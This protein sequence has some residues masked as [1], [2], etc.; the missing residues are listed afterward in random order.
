MLL[1]SD[2]RAADYGGAH[3]SKARDR[4]QIQRMIFKTAVRSSSMDI[5]NNLITQFERSCEKQTEKG[6]TLFLRGLAKLGEDGF[7][8]V[9]KLA[10]KSP[11]TQSGVQDHHARSQHRNHLS[12]FNCLRLKDEDGEESSEARPLGSTAFRLP[13][14]ATT[15]EQDP[16]GEHFP[17]VLDQMTQAAVNILENAIESKK[18]TVI[19]LIAHTWV[20]ALDTLISY[21]KFGQSMLE[22]V[23]QKRADDLK[24][25]IG[26]V[27]V[28]EDLREPKTLN[29]AMLLAS[30]GIELLLATV[31]RGTRSKSL[32]FVISKL[33][34]KA[35]HDVECLGEEG[36]KS[37]RVFLHIFTQRLT[38]LVDSRDQ[39][40]AEICAQV[41]IEIL[42][43][44]ALHPRTNLFNK[45][46]DEMV[47]LWR[48]AFE[49]NMEYM[50]KD[51]IDQRVKEWR[52]C[53]RDARYDE[54]IGLVLVGIGA[55][56]AAIKYRNDALVSI[57]LQ[58]FF[59]LTSQLVRELD[60]G[61]IVNGPAT[62]FFE[63]IRAKDLGAIFTTI[64]SLL[65][66]AD[67]IQPGRLDTLA[68]QVAEVAVTLS[69][70]RDQAF[71][72]TT[73]TNYHIEGVSQTADYHKG[74]I[75]GLEIDS[76]R[77]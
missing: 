12:D 23:V 74:R 18:K 41:G 28:E 19:R 34:I 63:G 33:W 7:Q 32:C 9:I 35:L 50:A 66:T 49:N 17:Q 43:A 65:E 16:L 14:I 5:I 51:L 30:V 68:L 6:D 36:E 69:T 47:W 39:V 73:I 77:P 10:T 64:I 52:V 3:T 24:Y 46:S 61:N 44:A 1:K 15:H 60:S 31:E 70:E 76:I 71:F 56:R 59:E 53:L 54:A 29:K 20:E 25:F 67:E 37:I 22:N 72:T 58:S 11:N 57:L 55:L 8:Y 2:I 62:S 40:N 75:R 21:P 27:S 45:F 42:G 13:R 26:T 4:I 38:S 48:L